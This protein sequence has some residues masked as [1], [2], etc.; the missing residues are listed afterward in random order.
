MTI[1]PGHLHPSETPTAWLRGRPGEMGWESGSII[2]TWKVAV[3]QGGIQGQGRTKKH[4]WG[5]SRAARILSW[6][7][8]EAVS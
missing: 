5:A 2:S 7:E 8:E 1:L 6:G 3:S 4:G